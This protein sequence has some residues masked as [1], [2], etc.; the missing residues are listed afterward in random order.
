MGLKT[1]KVLL[2]GVTSYS[3]NQKLEEFIKI[4]KDI[5]SLYNPVEYIRTDL[6]RFTPCIA[7]LESIK[8]LVQRENLKKFVIYVYHSTVEINMRGNT[9]FLLFQQKKKSSKLN[10]HLLEDLRMLH[11]IYAL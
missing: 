4:D 8:K 7:K 5:M 1:L 6:F 3:L 2:S 9:Y 10:I 11:K